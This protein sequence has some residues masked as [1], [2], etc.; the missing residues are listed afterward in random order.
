MFRQ[1]KPFTG[2]ETH[3]RCRTVRNNER[4]GNVRIQ[5]RPKLNIAVLVIQ[6]P[7]ENGIE[8]SRKIQ[9]RNPACSIIFVSDVYEVPHLCMVL[10]EQLAVQLPKI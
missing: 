5:I 10:K 4:Y 8:L 3:L 7:E 9:E 1:S 6:M 2:V